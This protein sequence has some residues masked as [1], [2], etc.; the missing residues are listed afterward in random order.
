MSKPAASKKAGPSPAV[1]R[2]SSKPPPD[3]KRA[4]VKPAAAAGKVDGKVDGKVTVSVGSSGSVEL[5]Q[6]MAAFQPYA[7]KGAAGT[8]HS[9]RGSA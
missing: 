4:A 7:E 2:A 8:S 3:K 6:F 1:S 9:R 5:A